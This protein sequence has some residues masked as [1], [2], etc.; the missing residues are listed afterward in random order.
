[1]PDRHAD[2]SILPEDGAAIQ[3]DPWDHLETSSHGANLLD[4]VI[5]RAETANLIASSN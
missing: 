3:M 5:W 4:S 2:P 1:M